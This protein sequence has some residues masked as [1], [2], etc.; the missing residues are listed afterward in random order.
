MTATTRSAS[1]TPWSMRSARPLAS[2]TFR[3]GTLRTSMGSGMA[4]SF[5]GGIGYDD[6]AGLPGDGVQ[7]VLE[8]ADHGTR[9][10]LLD[11]PAGRLDLRAHRAA[12]EVPLGGQRPQPPYVDPAER[13]GLRGAEPQR[14]LRDV[15]GDHEHVGGDGAGEQR[16][17][18]VLVDD[19]LD[20]AQTGR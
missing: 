14:R 20:A 11:E 4:V 9:A 13:L 12:G 3:I 5:V 6:G 8:V 17:A 16:G 2:D 1:S 18:Q 10:A 15:G 7:D 19:R